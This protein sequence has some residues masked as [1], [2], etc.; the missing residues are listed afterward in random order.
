LEISSPAPNCSD[1]LSRLAEHPDLKNLEA[2]FQARPPIPLAEPTLV[3]HLVFLQESSEPAG[4]FEH[5][6]Q[7]GRN[8]NWKISEF[9]DS[10]R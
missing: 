6:D 10:Y 5:L 4:D 1:R 2:E 9:S 8:G 3:S 7:F